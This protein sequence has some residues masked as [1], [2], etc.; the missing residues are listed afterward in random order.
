MWRHYFSIEASNAE[1]SQLLIKIEIE[2]G[3]LSPI[4]LKFG[5]WERCYCS[6]QIVGKFSN[7]SPYLY[8]KKLFF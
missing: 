3:D 2:Y 8:F 6:R 5:I 7:G 4:L 1:I